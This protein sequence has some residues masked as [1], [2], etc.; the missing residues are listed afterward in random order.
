MTT[1][2]KLIEDMEY[3]YISDEPFNDYAIKEY[4]KKNGVKEVC[5]WTEEESTCI[6]MSDL[7]EFI[8]KRIQTDYVEPYYAGAGYDK[9]ETFYEDRFPGLFVQSSLEVLTDHLVDTPFEILKYIA[10]RLSEEYWTRKELYEPLQGEL[11]AQNWE[12][13][14]YLIKHKVRF[15]FFNE[16]E[17]H[18]TPSYESY[19]DPYTILKKFRDAI[20]THEL[21]VE[22]EANKL[23]IYR[24]RMHKRQKRQLNF[25]EL[26]PPPEEIAQ[27]NRLSPA[28]ITMFYGALE[29]ETAIIEVLDINKP[30][31]FITTGR[32]SNLKALR[33]IDFTQLN[34]ISIFDEANEKKRET[35]VLLS[36]FLEDLT[37]PISNDGSQHIEYIPTQVVTEY[38]KSSFNS[39]LNQ[40]IH[41]LIFPS[42]KRKGHE[43]VVLFFNGQNVTNDK[44]ELDKYLLLNP[45]PIS[46][47]QINELNFS[48]L[49]TN[50]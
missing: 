25:T 50:F 6:L 21:I 38:L 43:N 48:V 13:F 47:Y 7:V 33:L 36:Q 20:F 26:G 16:S 8:D 19:S 15:M 28:G 35:Y 44:N 24:A 10:D 46:K 30:D 18:E 40:E 23:D 49:N 4:I 3:E 22:I 12:K 37:K 17:K 32:F 31:Y 5:D 9:E 27:A 42:T 29:E 11:D 39:D 2:E 1:I 41:G 14:K 45:M 34:W